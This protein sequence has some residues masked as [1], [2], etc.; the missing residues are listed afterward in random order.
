MKKILL[1]CLVLA[2]PL[3]GFGQSVI[4][5]AVGE[6]NLVCHNQGLWNITISLDESVEGEIITLHFTSPVPAVPVK[7]E[8]CFSFPQDNILGVW[9]P[10]N[11]YVELP[12]DWYWSWHSSLAQNMPLY[13]F[14]DNN[15]RNRLTV[16]CDEVRRYVGARMAIREKDCLVIGKISLFE[17]PEAPINDYTV[18]I[19]LDARKCQWYDAVKSAA[20]WMDY[21]AGVNP[22]PVPDAAFEPLYSSWYNFH[23]DIQASDIE[24]ECLIASQLGLKTIIVDDGW[25]TDD[26]NGCYAFCGDWEVSANRFPDIRSHIRK[27]QDMGM[28]YMLWYSVP[29]VGIHSKNYE[30]FQGKYLYYNQRNKAS[31]LDPRFPQVRQFLIDTYLN[32]MK[33]WQVDGF[34]L[35]FIDAFLFEGEDPA[36][37][38]DY[39]GRDIKSLPM[40]VDRL[41][42]DV[43]ARLSEFN[44]DVL[45]EFR[46]EYIGPAIRQYGNM[47]RAS[48]CPAN[49]RQNRQRIARLRLTSGHAAVHSDMLEWSRC[50]K[51]EN[52]AC[53]IM[54]ALFGVV[55]YSVMLRDI[56]SEQQQIIRHFIDFAGKH[57]NALLHGEFAAHYP[58]ACYPLLES[59]DNNERIIISYQPSIIVHT[60]LDR[61]IYL[62]NAQGESGVY[63]DLD[64]AAVAEIYDCMGRVCRKSKVRSGIGKLDIPNGGYALIRH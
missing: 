24:E 43:Y 26:N 27:I 42:S 19:R 25:Q 7:T 1:V 30:R 9:S 6:V 15:D 8:L 22:C 21:S 45:I 14:L 3:L 37:K 57:R 38:Q 44:P 33:E 63:L 39:E 54:N 47:L 46:Q 18:H 36:I 50:E 10:H 32:A 17:Q 61:N 5:K 13:C 51:N 35:D 4:S 12:P 53:N 16:A 55:Q 60:V 56:P 31:V 29:F 23:Q 59:Q 64:K 58:Q 2:A 41:M 11:D 20:S 52:I 40:A 28:K 48:D 62:M 49:P 34:K